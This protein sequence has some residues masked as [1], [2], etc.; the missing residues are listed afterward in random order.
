M[1]NRDEI[2]IKPL[3]LRP[4]QVAKIFGSHQIYLD[5]CR[6]GWLKPIIKRHKL[7]LYDHRAVKRVWERI[8]Q[9]EDPRDYIGH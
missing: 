8:R 3:G 7:T 6:A 1:D 9:G 4:N 5:T 2:G